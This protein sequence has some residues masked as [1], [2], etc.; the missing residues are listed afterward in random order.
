M[1]RHFSKRGD[2][3]TCPLVL[4][5][6][7]VCQGVLRIAVC[8]GVQNSVNRHLWWWWGVKRQLTMLTDSV[9]KHSTNRKQLPILHFVYQENQHTIRR[10]TLN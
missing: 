6:K 9:I 5:V 4:T 2:F 1:V 3:V 7:A 10:Y 8:Q